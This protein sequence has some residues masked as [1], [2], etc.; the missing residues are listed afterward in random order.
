MTAK[1]WLFFIL[2]IAVGVGLGLLYGWVI[3]PVEYIDT[4]PATLRTDFRTD[5]VL[6]VAETFAADQDIDA[7]A[8][9]LGL[10]GSQPP[11]QIASEAIAFAQQNGYTS[12]DLDLL[13]SLAVALQVWQPAAQPAGAQP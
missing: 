3:S 7:A 9:S 13:Q 2:S 4:T 10:F 1:R 5:Y 11:A 6:M 8:R 12:T